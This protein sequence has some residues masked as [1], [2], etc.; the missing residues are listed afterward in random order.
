VTG[1]ANKT[2]AGLE[3]LA[4]MLTGRA[5][6]RLVA[7]GSAW[8]FNWREGV[9]HA[10]A[11][12]LLELP[13]ELCRGL[14]AHEGAHAAITRIQDVVPPATHRRYAALLNAVEDCRIE[15][16]LATVMPGAATWVRAF[17]DAVSAQLEGKEAPPI[18][19]GQFL[20]GLLERWWVGA[21][22]PV[23]APEVHEALA[24][25]DA[26]LRKAFSCIPDEA[27]PSAKTTLEHQRRMW[28]ELQEGVL[29]AFD[30]LRDRDRADGLPVDELLAALM[31]DRLP[32]LGHGGRQRASVRHGAGKGSRVERAPLDTVATAYDEAWSRVHSLADQASDALLRVL[33]P[34]RRLGWQRD[35]RSG[36]RVNLR[37]AMESVHDARAMDRLWLRPRVP[38]RHEPECALV[39]DVSSSME[40]ERIDATFDALVLLLEATRRAGIP[41][42]VWSFSWKCACELDARASLDDRARVALGGLREA[43]GCS[44]NLGAALAEVH[45]NLAASTA[46]DRFVFVLSDGDP[47]DPAATTEAIARLREDGV[48]VLALGL[49]QETEKLARFFDHALIDVA[50][51]DVAERLGD[52]LLG[53]IAA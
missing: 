52:L 46:T 1:S 31:T 47:S 9:I 37:R 6:L 13:E 39:I 48:H 12:E 23:Y 20:L 5:E 40:G 51:A 19:A 3:L 45:E 27:R 35:Q 15:T 8:C 38:N 17:N 29:E 16:W 33:Q 50:P 4:R 18:R 2:A 44:T 22:R 14:V 24:A 53:A 49:G 10:P 28:R 42:S 34:R 36:V 41:C 25:V 21:E 11:D 43:V 32:G 7:T 30:A 26:P